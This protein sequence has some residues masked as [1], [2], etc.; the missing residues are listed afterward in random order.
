[1]SSACIVRRATGDAIDHNTGIDT[2]TYAV[3]YTGKC[4]L[5]FDFARVTEVQAAGQ[6]VS[7]Q[8]PVLS[9]P[10]LT[11]GDVLTN[12]VAEITANPLDP[13]LVGKKFRIA[14]VHAQSQA[15]ARRFP[16]EVSS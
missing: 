14:G 6:T 16:V 5:R 15:T 13:S 12:D 4:R 7:D 3:I 10:V 1:M 2:P 11:S 9:L 8:R